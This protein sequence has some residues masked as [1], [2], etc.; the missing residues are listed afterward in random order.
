MHYIEDQGIDA[1]SFW[2]HLFYDGYPL[3]YE[4]VRRHNQVDFLASGVFAAHFVNTVSETFLAEIVGGQH[5]FVKE[6]LRRELTAKYEAG[7]AAG[8][9][10]CPGSDLRSQIG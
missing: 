9:T 4:Q 5:D 8:I 1:A 7:C 3:D 10:K 6:S 2:K